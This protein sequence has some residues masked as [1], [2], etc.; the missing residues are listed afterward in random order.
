MTGLSLLCTQ[1]VKL[2]VLSGSISANRAYIITME[3]RRMENCKSDAEFKSERLAVLEK[4]I[5]K[6]IRERTELELRKHPGIRYSTSEIHA[7]KGRIVSKL[8]EALGKLK[9][10]KK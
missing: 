9:K 4:S 2:A 8:D 1:T 5:S 6:G 3:N 7:M 10:G